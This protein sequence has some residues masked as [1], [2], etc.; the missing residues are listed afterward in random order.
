MLDLYK[1][2]YSMEE[3]KKHIYDINLWDILKTQVIDEV[4]AIKYILNHRYQLS[5]SEKMI[6]VQVVMLHQPHLKKKKLFF[7]LKNMDLN[8]DTDDIKFDDY[9]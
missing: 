4:F 7:Y 5:E 6:D 2:K 8:D 9:N 3:M 1:K